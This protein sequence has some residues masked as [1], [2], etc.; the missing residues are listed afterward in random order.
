MPSYKLV[1]FNGRGRA[2]L[3]RL[4]FVQA[5]VAYEDVR[6]EREEWPKYKAA[7]PTGQAPYLYIDDM[8]IAQSIAIARYL[9]R[10]HGLYGSGSLEAAKIDMIV[11]TMDELMMGFYRSHFAEGEVKTKLEKQFV[12]KVPSVMNLLENSI[13]ASGSGFLVGSK[14]SLADITT[15][16]YVMELRG[17]AEVF[18]K[19]VNDGIAAHPATA[20][21]IKKVENMPNIKQWL[22]KRPKSEF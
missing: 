12:D 17:K 4:L 19:A 22:E 8:V 15:M 5:G 3:N 14:V 20:E 11:D 2:E 9:A 18:S 10:E 1:Y 21:L 13:K 7:S 6:C 16:H